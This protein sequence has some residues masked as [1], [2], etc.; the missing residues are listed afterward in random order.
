MELTF[1][2]FIQG[3]TVPVIIF[4][5][6]G[7]ALMIVEMFTPGFGVAG[8]LG[9]LCFVLAIVFRADSLA[10]ALWMIILVAMMVCV[11]LLI[12]LRSAT[13]GKISR[14]AIVLQDQL[15]SEEG[16]LSSDD[17]QFFVGKDG[18]ALTVLRP[19]GMA[20][21]DGVKLNVV[22]DGEYI[23]AGTRV[24]VARVEGNRILVREKRE[25]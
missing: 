11:L 18:V 14:S 10:A 17:L 25:A 21:F 8:V 12:F 6:L 3:F 5:V 2:E 23:P 7:T 22:S 16:Y 9:I 24:V 1:A 20:D 13:K 4:M 15:K 19:S